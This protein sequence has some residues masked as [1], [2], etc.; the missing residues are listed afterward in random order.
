MRETRKINTAKF[1]TIFRGSK[2]IE[3]LEAS[4]PGKCKYFLKKVFK[5]GKKIGSAHSNVKYKVKIKIKCEKKSR[6]SNFASCQRGGGRQWPNLH[7]IYA[8]LIS[9]EVTNYNL[10]GLLESLP[11]SWNETKNNSVEKT[12]PC[13]KCQ[14]KAKLERALNLKVDDSQSMSK[15]WLEPRIPLEI[16]RFSWIHIPQKRLLS[17]LKNV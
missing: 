12:S 9:V 15:Q 6:T 11:P 8:K 5:G 2:R 16:M 10:P 14:N 13:E 1:H 7:T 4:S 3:L 17:R